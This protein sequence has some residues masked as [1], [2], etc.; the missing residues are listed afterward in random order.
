MKNAGINTKTYKPHSLRSASS[1][2][3]VENGIP[4]TNVKHH[5]NWSQQAF[6]F[7][8]YYLKP[9]AAKAT[10]TNIANSIFLPTENITTF[11]EESES[12]RIVEENSTNNTNVDEDESKNV[13]TTRPWYLRWWS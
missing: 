9:T 5:G 11:G 12:T 8:K 1:T 7:E 10:S 6:T 4:L 2:K 3:A 13:V